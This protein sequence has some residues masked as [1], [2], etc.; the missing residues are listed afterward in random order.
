MTFRIL[1]TLLIIST[2]FSCKDDTL[3]TKIDAEDS[4][5]QF[6]NR[7]IENDS[8]NILDFEYVYN[9]S[10][11]GIADFNKDGLQD[12]FF[13]GNQ[14]ANKLYLNKGDFKFEDISVKAGIEAANR[15]CAGVVTVD[16]NSDGWMD[17][18][19]AATVKEPSSER[20]N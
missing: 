16:I 20:Q 5:I 2:V 15:W 7:I 9:G 19:V 3:F 12:V 11:V 13:S 6:S 4:G 14:V 18:Y 8:M 17:V 10:G 1:T